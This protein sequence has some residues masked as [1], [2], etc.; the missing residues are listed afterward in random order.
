MLSGKEGNVF[1]Y[2]NAVH[3]FARKNEVLTK[4]SEI[5]EMVGQASLDI[6]ICQALPD[7]PAFGFML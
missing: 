7:L 3:V 2:T 4:Q 6:L 5:Y 1:L